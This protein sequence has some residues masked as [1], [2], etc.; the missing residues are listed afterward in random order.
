M[1]AIERGALGGVAGGI[2]TEIGR[3]GTGSG[4]DIEALKTV[5][6][7]AD[8]KVTASGGAHTVHD[9]VALKAAMPQNVD[10]C[11]VGSALY[12]ETLDLA[13]AIKAVA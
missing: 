8:I 4:F 1:N 9:I 7:V 12:K 6:S 5:A 3:D 13:E 11:I 10:S 2:S